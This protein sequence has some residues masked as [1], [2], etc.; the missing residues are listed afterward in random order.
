MKKILCT[1]MM[2]AVTGAF[3]QDNPPAQQPIDPLDPN[4]KSDQVRQYI[5]T[6]SEV[7]QPWERLVD[8]NRNGTI[9]IGELMSARRR[10]VGKQALRRSGASINLDDLMADAVPELEVA[11]RAD[12]PVVVESR[13]EQRY[14]ADQNGTLDIEETAALLKDRLAQARM[15]GAVVIASALEER[16]DLDEDGMLMSQEIEL[17]LRHLNVELDPAPEPVPEE[18][19]PPG[20]ESQ[21]GPA[22]ARSEPVVVPPPLE[23]EPGA[24]GAARPPV[25]SP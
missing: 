18:D 1:L 24:T 19:P 16:L 2:L 21:P 9:E 10:S 4:T 6:Q 17:G 11:S 15:A 3:A 20:I 14:D 23:D 5:Q 8:R 25:L 7:D 22:E 12:E 13:L